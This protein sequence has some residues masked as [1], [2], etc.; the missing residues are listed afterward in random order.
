MR[1]REKTPLGW[2]AIV[3]LTHLIMLGVN[4][5]ACVHV[6]YNMDCINNPIL[7]II[8]NVILVIIFMIVII[9]NSIIYAIE[10]MN[11]E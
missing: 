5:W 10:D 8:I 6:I 1:I 11:F 3:I 9:R 7:T 2:R 4:V